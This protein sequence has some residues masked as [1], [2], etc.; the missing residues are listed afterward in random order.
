MAVTL[1]LFQGLQIKKASLSGRLF[2]FNKF[3]SEFE[4]QCHE[5]A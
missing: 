5:Y 2:L 4:A 3:L 1:N